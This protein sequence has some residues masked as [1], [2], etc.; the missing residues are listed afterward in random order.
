MLG[1]KR[2]LVCPEN[3]IIVLIKQ[4]CCD[5]LMQLS[6]L[7]V[8]SQCTIFVAKL[9]RD[10]EETAEEKEKGESHSQKKSSVVPEDDD[11]AGKAVKEM[12]KY[13]SQSYNQKFFDAL[14]ESKGF[15]AESGPQYECI[16]F[17]ILLYRYPELRKRVYAL[18][19]RYFLRVRSSISALNNVQLLEGQQSI[20]TLGEV[21]SI[22]EVLR[23]LKNETSHWITF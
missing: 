2:Y 7:E 16:L 23:N 18:L 8:D 17:D 10:I 22:Y 19:V 20:E 1:I 15:E 4:M 21:K 6:C 5:I 12:Q 11:D 9:K 14:T 13:T 3:D